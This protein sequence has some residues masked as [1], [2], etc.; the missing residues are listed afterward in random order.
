MEL[1]QEFMTEKFVEI[2]KHYI[3]MKTLWRSFKNTEQY[4]NTSKSQRKR[5]NDEIKYREFIELVK[6]LYPH[7][8]K[9]HSEH[10]QCLMGAKKD[11]GGELD[12]DYP[13]SFTWM[14]I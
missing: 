13:K 4:L 6:G 14:N 8:Y 7:L 1:V 12:F 11:R 2:P 9:N 10:G 5:K 3:K